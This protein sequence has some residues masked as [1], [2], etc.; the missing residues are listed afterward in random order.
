MERQIAYQI[1]PR[2]CCDSSGFG[3]LLHVEVMNVTGLIIVDRSYEEYRLAGK[4]FRWKATLRQSIQHLSGQHAVQSS[5]SGRLS[6]FR[7]LP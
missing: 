5:P 2:V 7:I 6:L 1:H 4:C 3:I